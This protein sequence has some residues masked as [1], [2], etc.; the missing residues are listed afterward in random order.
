MSGL[1]TPDRMRISTAQFNSMVAGHWRQRVDR[2]LRKAVPEYSQVTQGLRDDFLA[3][4]V[5]GAETAHFVTEQGAVGYVLGAWYLEPGFESRSPLLTA[6]L[7]SELPEFR[8]LHAMNAWLE[9]TILEP[10]NPAAADDALRK[11]FDMTHAWGK[12]AAGRA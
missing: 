3:L 6:L 9:A 11:A 1:D 7:A 4:A 8:R 12:G 10:A 5:D 2:A